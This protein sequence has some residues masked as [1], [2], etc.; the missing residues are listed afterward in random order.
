[1]SKKWEYITEHIKGSSDGMSVAELNARGNVGWE[2]VSVRD[3]NKI[4][5]NDNVMQSSDELI[6]EY[7]FKRKV[8]K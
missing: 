8:S 3:Y 1:M 2:L 4:F 5:N 6:T 7:I